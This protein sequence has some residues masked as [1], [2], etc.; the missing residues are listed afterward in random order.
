MLEIMNV[1]IK[2]ELIDVGK[3]VLPSSLTVWISSL[4]LVRIAE[5]VKE[6]GIALI[7]IAN[8]IFVGYKIW[9]IARQMRWDK[10]DRN[11]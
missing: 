6:V 8:L 1:M 9:K 10:Q 11:D 4:D 2:H 3:V 7:V 5:V